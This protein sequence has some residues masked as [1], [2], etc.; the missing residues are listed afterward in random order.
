MEVRF[1]CRPQEKPWDIIVKDDIALGECTCAEALEALALAVSS[2]YQVV[3]KGVVFM[4]ED[5][6]IEK[7]V[8]PLKREFVESGESG[9]FRKGNKWVF[10]ENEYGIK[11]PEGGVGAY[12]E[13]E[14]CQCYTDD[15]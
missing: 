11:L 12:P 1:I 15:G 14:R 4:R 8:Y 6:R 7:T 9:F 10:D 13:N 5:E 3:Q 2:N